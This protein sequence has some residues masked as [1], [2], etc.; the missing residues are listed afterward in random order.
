MPSVP[1]F[2]ST[3]ALRDPLDASYVSSASWYE[4]G[5]DLPGDLPVPRES[6]RTQA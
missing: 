5:S 2:P 4:L 6:T 3:T 1:T